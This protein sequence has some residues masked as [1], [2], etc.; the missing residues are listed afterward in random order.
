M[1]TCCRSRCK[2]LMDMVKQSSNTRLMKVSE[3]CTY[4][5]S[6]MSRSS[7]CCNRNYRTSWKVFEDG[8]TGEMVVC[9]KRFTWVRV[10]SR[11]WLAWF[12]WMACWWIKET[13]ESSREGQSSRTY[14]PTT[15]SIALHPTSSQ[16]PPYPSSSP[17]IGRHNKVACLQ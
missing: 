16:M 7:R 13:R 11:S 3:K 8:L 1:F 12:A 15:A 4:S 17:H 2:C 6:R 14:R 10:L 5:Q 9:W